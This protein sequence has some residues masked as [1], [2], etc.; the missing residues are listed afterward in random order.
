MG[1]PPLKCPKKATTQTSATPALPVPAAA[2]QREMCQPLDPSLLPLGSSQTSAATSAPPSDMGHR[3][4]NGT[5]QQE[6]PWHPQVQ[7]QQLLRPSSPHPLQRPCWQQPCWCYL[8]SS[9][10]LPQWHLQLLPGTCR[11]WASTPGWDPL[12]A[13]GTA[14]PVTGS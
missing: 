14:A 2:A 6:L 8:T 3:F 13:V 4:I 11:G 5:A 12:Q 9:P 7:E 1:P 10:V